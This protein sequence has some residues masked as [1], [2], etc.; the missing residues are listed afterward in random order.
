MATGTE[1]YA[2]YLQGDTG[3]LEELVVKYGDGLIGY[4]YCYLRDFAAAEDVMEDV[5]AVLIIKRKRFVECSAFEAYLFRIA[6]NK[7]IDRL[8]KRGHETFLN[9]DLPVAS[10]QNVEEEALRSLRDEKVYKALLGLSPDYRDVLYLSYY[11]GFSVDEIKSAMRKTAKQ[12]YNLTTRAKSALKQI[13]I[14]EGIGHED[15]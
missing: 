12:V 8:R 14:K 13:L 3:A 15:L 6:R 7:C 9:D 10:T 4:A 5:F 2:R 1:I 11:Q